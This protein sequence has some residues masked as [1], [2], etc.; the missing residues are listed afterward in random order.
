MGLENKKELINT[1]KIDMNVRL[2]VI[3]V[4]IMLSFMMYFLGVEVSLLRIGLF[5]VLTGIYYILYKLILVYDLASLGI[6]YI[7]IIM[8]IFLLLF[9]IDV[10]GG[11]RS[12]FFLIYFILPLVDCFTHSN[13]K[14]LLFSG[15]VPCAVYPVYILLSPG[16]EPTGGNI[17]ILVIRVVF[18]LV[19][20]LISDFYQRTVYAEKEKANEARDEVKRVNE[21]LE[22]MV[23]IKT[24]E[25]KNAQEQLIQSAKMAAVGQLASG[26]AHEI[27]NPLTVILG[28]T[29]LLLKQ[30]TE[31]GE[32]RESLLE[33]EEYTNRCKRIIKDLLGF[34]RQYK[35]GI[36]KVDVNSLINKA[37][38]LV[39]RQLKLDDIN[40]IKKFG[41][42]LPP[43]K[44]I[45]NLLEQVFFNLI[46]NARQS[47]P[48][49]GE[50]IITTRLNGNDM[51]RIEVQDN[52]E[53]IKKEDIP[54]VFD[55][56]FT[57]KEVGKGTGLGLFVT[58]SIIEKNVGKIRVESE[59]EG[60]GANFIIDLPLYKG[61][62]VK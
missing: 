58:Y 32:V 48:E 61:D 53:G 17:S 10:T 47:M 50:I 60:R 21:S 45:G 39:S 20:A 42:E 57:T 8:D 52:G 28:Q 13:R 31:S 11:F 1:L 14:I 55:P 4:G 34:S 9:A 33:I 37:I 18:I 26:T 27:N 24:Q 7:F 3:G 12:P 5:M 62:K 40:I 35:L 59:G 43:A 54:R 23:E 51:I 30:Y 22:M 49:G 29:Q 2:S 56:F 41:E 15:V 16:F 25:L 36:K 38:E 44:G 46:I 19:I 6:K